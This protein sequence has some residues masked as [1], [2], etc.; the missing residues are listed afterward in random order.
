M[1]LFG[2]TLVIAGGVPL[3]NPSVA[4]PSLTWGAL[5]V[6]LCAGYPWCAVIRPVTVWTARPTG[7]VVALKLV[8]VLLL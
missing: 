5:I 3:V 2:R 6:Q 8:G 4:E 1:P 7:R